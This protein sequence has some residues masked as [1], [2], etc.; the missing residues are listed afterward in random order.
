M[1]ARALTAAAA[2]NADL[3]PIARWLYVEPREHVTSCTC[4]RLIA[5]RLYARGACDRCHGSGIVAVEGIDLAPERED[6]LAECEHC[7][8][9]RGE[10]CKPGCPE[11]HCSRHPEEG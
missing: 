7:G 5:E 10:R 9:A 4:V 3:P 8:A 1:S 11:G 2:L 6:G